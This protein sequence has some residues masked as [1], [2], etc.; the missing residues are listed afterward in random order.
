MVRS[1]VGSLRR[2]LSE[3]QFR[4]AGICLLSLLVGGPALAT[5]AVYIGSDANGSPVV[6]RTDGQRILD[7][8]AS[9]AANRTAGAPVSLARSEFSSCELGV[10]GSFHCFQNKLCKV[11]EAAIPSFQGKISA[12]GSRLEGTVGCC[13]LAHAFTAERTTAFGRFE[14][15]ELP[16]EPQ[17][18][19]AAHACTGDNET[20]CLN[21]SRFTAEVS[22]TRPNGQTGTGKVQTLP[23]DDSGLFWFFNV[24]NI[25]MLVKVLNGCGV[26]NRYWV[27]YSPGTNVG[28]NLRV[29]DTQTGQQKTYLNNVGTVAQSVADT[30]AFAACP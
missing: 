19:D 20:L 4:G 13:F 17:V 7:V 3:W 2:S 16:V 29:T 21:N 6:V 22:W 5:S 30:S 23:Q 25:E 15:K 10:D 11:G 9:C 14:P 27:F 24:D 8:R 18:A 12:E 28:F 1:R 26:N